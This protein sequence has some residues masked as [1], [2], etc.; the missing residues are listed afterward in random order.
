MFANLARREK[1]AQVGQ[2]SLIYSH[3]AVICSNFTSNGVLSRETNHG[4]GFYFYVS[5]RP[6]PL[7]PTLKFVFYE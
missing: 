1:I 7:W 2:L 6:S 3:Q 5:S 4:N